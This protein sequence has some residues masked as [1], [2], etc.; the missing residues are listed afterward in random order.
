MTSLYYIKVP[1]LTIVPCHI[2]LQI[3]LLLFE[4][5][6]KTHSLHIDRI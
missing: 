1:V 2:F 3:T 4:M 6:H 5:A